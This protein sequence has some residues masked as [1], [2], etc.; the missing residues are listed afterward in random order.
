MNLNNDNQWYSRTLMDMDLLGGSA[1]SVTTSCKIRLS[2]AGGQGLLARMYASKG[3]NLATTMTHKV[4]ESTLVVQVDGAAQGT[5][6]IRF[7]NGYLAAQENFPEYIDELRAQGK[8]LCEFGKLAVDA[9]VRSKRV[10]GAMFQLA[11]LLAFQI[12]GAT[13]ILAEVNPTHANFYQKMLDFER[14]GD[15]RNC[16]RVGAPAVLL[17]LS[18]EKGHELQAATKGRGFYP[19]FF[20]A[21]DRDTLLRQLTRQAQASG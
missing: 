2:R 17:L 20:S 11:W 21:A 10:L 6:T 7:D 18:A 16:D 4:D 8:R 13:D 1:D 14:I 19:Y 15:E 9:S 3:Y 12:R 5:L